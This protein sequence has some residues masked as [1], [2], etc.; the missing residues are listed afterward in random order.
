M[1][2]EIKTIESTSYLNMNVWDAM[3]KMAQTF[4]KSGALPT[5]VSNT[6]QLMMLFQAGYELG[7]KPVESLRNLYIVKGRVALQGSAMLKK[8]IDAG[9]KIKWNEVG[10]EK[11]KA[12]FE[13]QGMEPFVA[14]YTMAQADAGK[15]SLTFKDGKWFKKPTYA[16]F[17][18]N[19]L[20][21][22]VVSTAGKF[23]CADIIEGYDLVEDVIDI[24]TEDIPV[25]S[26]N[27]TDASKIDVLLHKI[28]KAKTIKS[29][30]KLS[31]DF[32]TLSNA[33]QQIAMSAYAKRQQELDG[34]NIQPAVVTN[35]DEVLE[36]QTSNEA[37]VE[38]KATKPASVL[39]SIF[40][41]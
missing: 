23:Y 32:S 30:Q 33:D 8:M 24:V 2:N 11:V 29:L 1:T 28:Q 38:E 40:K 3:D 10:P 4:I 19:M 37:P 34:E 35:T 18:E 39:D 25:D 17:P 14:E 20:R 7:M 27:D 31:G 26:T 21:W 5:G 13:R 22:K 15:V 36:N 16:A 12:T 41:K 6:S 9:V